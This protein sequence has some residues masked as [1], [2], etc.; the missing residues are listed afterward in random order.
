MPPNVLF[1]ITDQQRP[2]TLG[3]LGHAHMRTPNID[4]L[5]ESGLCLTNAYVQS[6]VCVPSRACMLSCKYAHSHGA[7]DNGMW[8]RDED[9]NYIH[10]FRN[11]G[12]H[13]A[14][15][16]KIHSKPVH[17]PCGFEFR[18]V[19]ENK[20]H[21][22]STK[23][24][25]ED[26]DYGVML[27]ALGHDRPG[28]CYQDTEHDWFSELGAAIWPLPEELYY[29]NVVGA[30][31][32]DYVERHDFETPLYLHVGFPGPHDPFDVTESDLAA[33]GDPELPEPVGYEGEFE[34]KPSAQRRYMEM[35]ETRFCG[36]CIPL[37]S[38]ATPEKLHRMRRHYFA[39][40][41]A[42][43]RWVGRLCEALA[44]RG[45][46]DN[47]LVVFTSDHGETLGDHGMI[48][49]FG[50][51][52][53]S[54]ARVPCVFRGP[55]VP[56]RALESGLFETL[57]FGPTLLELCGV[58]SDQEFE[59]RSAVP[60]LRDG[61]RIHDAVFSEYEQRLMIRTDRWKLV[62][63]AKD[64]EGEM[65]DMAADPD[66]LDNRYGDAEVAP[67]QARLMARLMQ[68]RFGPAVR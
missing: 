10:D 43:D 29:D 41:Y 63:Y 7:T 56:A 60:L 13:T 49:K 44:E 26:D 14:A 32:V 36:A 11:A 37:L 35:M 59:G 61:S 12:Y 51:H 5:A 21:K 23:P 19:A 2:D 67:E 28:A 24:G 47:T 1:I 16:G 62:Y 20:N 48:Y 64:N 17:H 30:K 65:Y 33:Y 68:W 42:V 50:T 9:T 55:G 27:R 34:D 45:Q 8:I 52:Y 46:L 38:E 54:V 31:A 66:E 25:F 57:D 53:D 40:V 6:T 15:I 58:R 4:R 22:G 39:N 18:W 3:C